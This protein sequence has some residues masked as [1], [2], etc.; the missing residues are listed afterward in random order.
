MSPINIYG[1][2][3][4]TIHYKRETVSASQFADLLNRSGLGARRPVDDLPRLQRM[5]DGAN[6]VIT[7]RTIEAG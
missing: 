5:L 1:D 6:L 7:A 4:T 2:I 3:D